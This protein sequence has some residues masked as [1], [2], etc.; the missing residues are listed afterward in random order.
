MDAAESESLHRTTTGRRERNRSYRAF[1]ALLSVKVYAGLLPI[2]INETFISKYFA[3]VT[4][5]TSKPVE[6]LKEAVGATRLLAA[7]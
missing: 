6:A 7:A 5:A 4:T 1:P 2:F 3:G